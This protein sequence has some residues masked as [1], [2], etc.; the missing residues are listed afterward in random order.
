MNKINTITKN[1]FDWLKKFGKLKDVLLNRKEYGK[2]IIII[3]K[4]KSGKRMSISELC[5]FMF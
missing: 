5:Q 4:R 2:V 3:G 1:V